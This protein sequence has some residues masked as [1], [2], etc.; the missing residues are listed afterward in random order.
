M[1]HELN[2]ESPTGEGAVVNDIDDNLQE[3]MALIYGERR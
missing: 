2:F 3:L 1:S